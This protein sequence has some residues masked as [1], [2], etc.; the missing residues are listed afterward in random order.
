MA[1]TLPTDIQSLLQLEIKAVDKIHHMMLQEHQLLIARDS[2][3][4]ERLTAEKIQVMHEIEQI[5]LQ[6]L[7]LLE[8]TPHS[9]RQVIGEQLANLC[10]N[11]PNTLKLWEQLQE[12]AKSCQLQNQ[13][14]GA[15][16][17]ASQN[18]IGQLRKLLRGDTSGLTL[19]GSKGE[20]NETLDSHPLSSA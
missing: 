10:H 13:K 16:I 4:L 14:N 18:A 3:L 7:A 1:N 9:S 20:L 11:D 19:Y 15:I 5:T 6:R 17:A 8:L 2:E 12:L